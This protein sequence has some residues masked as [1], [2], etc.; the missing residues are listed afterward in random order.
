MGRPYM[1]PMKVV[2]KAPAQVSDQRIF[3]PFTYRIRLS[4]KNGGF[5]FLVHDIIFINFTLH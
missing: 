4:E 2:R 3:L 5:F 1:H